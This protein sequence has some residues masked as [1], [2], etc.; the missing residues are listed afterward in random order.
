MEDAKRI[1][2]AGYCQVLEDGLDVC[3]SE[4]DLEFSDHDEVLE[5]MY[6]SD[7]LDPEGKPILNRARM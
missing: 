5:G 6:T 4:S 3:N 1:A 2:V 7:M